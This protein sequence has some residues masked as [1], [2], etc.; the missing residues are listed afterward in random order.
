MGFER[1]E[2]RV[3]PCEESVIDDAFV[4]EGFNLMFSVVTLLV[5]LVLLCSDEGAFID[6]RVYFDIGIVT[7]F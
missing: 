6:V 7:K 4:F 2:K 1:I 3:N 5:D